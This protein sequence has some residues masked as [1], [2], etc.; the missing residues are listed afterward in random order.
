MWL[1][2]R[3]E[4]FSERVNLDGT[5][6][7]EIVKHIYERAKFNIQG[8]LSNMLNKPTKGDNEILEPTLN[9]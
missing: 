9:L 8:K 7:A 3:K 2:M 1:H 6:K 5:E 4:Q